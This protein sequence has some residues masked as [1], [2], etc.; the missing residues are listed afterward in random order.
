LKNRKWGAEVKGIAKQKGEIILS[1][2]TR[3]EYLSACF[4]LGLKPVII[5]LCPPT[6]SSNKQSILKQI[7]HNTLAVIASFPNTIYGTVDNIQEIA[8]ICTANNICLHI[9]SS[10]LVPFEKELLDSLQLN[11]IFKKPDLLASISFDFS[12]FSWL[13][14][15]C[16]MLFFSNLKMSQFMMFTSVDCLA[17]PYVSQKLFCDNNSID[18]LTTFTIFLIIGKAN[19][20]EF[21]RKLKE[22]RN[23]FIS[24][25][26]AQKQ[27]E[28]LG[29]PKGENVCF[30]ITDPNF[31]IW[32]LYDFLSK[33]NW[34]VQANLDPPSITA[35]IANCDL[36]ERD[37]SIKNDLQEFFNKNDNR[38][39]QSNMA[40]TQI[41][42]CSKLKI[43]VKM[44]SRDQC[45]KVLN[46]AIDI[47]EKCFKFS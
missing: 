28:I 30:R 26:A 11:A 36:R 45:K 24:K 4:Y 31:N 37:E 43:Q 39:N 14:E 9:D 35:T 6:F 10:I 46:E 1:S 25:I 8:A 13:T 29:I 16:S 40:K 44:V 18:F 5:P 3:P 42:G 34:G 22:S 15:S 19:L 23:Y 27:L 20:R 17:G 7:N 41:F 47:V 2:S 38:G 21:A 32:G 12:N 33:K